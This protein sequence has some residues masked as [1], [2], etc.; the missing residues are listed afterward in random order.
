MI[1]CFIIKITFNNCKMLR[2]K[3]KQT[4]IPKTLFLKNL[5]AK[6][7]KISV[8]FTRIGEIDTVNERFS[9]DATLF[10]KWKENTNILQKCNAN[11]IHDNSYF[12]DSKKLW[13]P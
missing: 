8:I 9:C 10:I 1:Q 7:V 12:W 11:D 3:R 4:E 6:E 13:D 2:I 5:N